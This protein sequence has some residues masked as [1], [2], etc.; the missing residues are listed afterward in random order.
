MAI[1]TKESPIQ[2]AVLNC[3][4]YY[5]TELKNRKI[6]KQYRIEV[7]IYDKN[8]SP[9]IGAKKD[10]AVTIKMEFYLDSLLKPVRL[11]QTQIQ[12][13][14]VPS[15]EVTKRTIDQCFLIFLK[16]CIGVFGIIAEQKI[17]ARSANG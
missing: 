14:D 12:V 17:K 4:D 2:Q 8:K 15:K 3:I 10:K 5:N 11:W 16:E 1:K 9:I 7:N 13:G 6:D